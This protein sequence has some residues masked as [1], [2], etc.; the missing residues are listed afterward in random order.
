[1]SGFKQRKME[2]FGMKS[3]H[4]SGA[5]ESTEWVPLSFS[6]K[7]A[8]EPQWTSKVYMGVGLWAEIPPDSFDQ[9]SNQ[10][11]A[12][13]HWAQTTGLVHRSVIYYI[14]NTPIQHSK[15]P[16][17]HRHTHTDS[18]CASSGS[19]CRWLVATPS[20]SGGKLPLKASKVQPAAL[21]AKPPCR[22]NYSCGDQL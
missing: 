17:T 7:N 21:K 20:F 3:L 18:C 13:E 5:A 6:H 4:S 19:N 10:T 12:L 8:D 9:P 11:T 15:T 14:E 22:W 1:M 16:L 2:A